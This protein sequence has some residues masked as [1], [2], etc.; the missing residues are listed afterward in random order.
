VC[1]HSKLGSMSRAI[2]LVLWL[3]A[4]MT[5]MAGCA[6]RRIPPQFYGSPLL[7]TGQLDT[8]CLEGRCIVLDPGHGGAFAGALG[9]GGL[10]EDDVNLGVALYLWGLLRD[11]GAE[12]YLTR[13]S[14]TDFLIGQ[15]A[16]LGDDLRRRMEV[17][18]GFRPELFISL[19]HNADMSRSPEKNRIE[20]YFKMSDDGPSKDAAALI[21]KHLS[22]NLSIEQG[23]LVAGNYFVLR[24][25][26]CPAVLGEPSYLTN[27]W[28]EEKLKLAQ[29]QLLEAQAYFAGIVEYFSR[30]TPHILT[31]SPCDTVIHEAR[32]ALLASIASGREGIDSNEVTC[33]LDGES[34][35]VGVNA[36]ETLLTAVAEAPLAGGT[37]ELCFCYRNRKG[38]SSGQSCCNF[39]VSL[40]AASIVVDAYP[41]GLPEEGGLLVVARTRDANGN[42]MRDGTPVLF[43]SSSGSFSEDSVGTLSGIAST[44]F[45]ASP[46]TGE[47]RIGVTCEAVTEQLVM[48]AIPV[49]TRVLR[50]TSEGER[51]ALA[52]VR[53]WHGDS[54][55]CE[56]TPQG[57][58]VIPTDAARELVLCSNGF[59]P[60]PISSD[61]ISTRTADRVEEARMAP[62]ARAALRR[63][64]VAVD[65]GTPPTIQPAG[66]DS[67]RLG[68]AEQLVGML[69]GAGAEVL[70][71][72]ENLT[73]AERVKKA[74]LFGA[75]RYLRLD[76]GTQKSPALLH[77][78]GS[79]AGNSLAEGCA[80]WWNETLSSRRPEVREDAHYV[81]RQT[82]CPA[83]VLRLALNTKAPCPEF[84]SGVAY[85]L[86]LATLSSFGLAHPDMCRL[87]V[88]SPASIRD[89]R[90]FAV[91]D[92][93]LFLPFPEHGKTSFFCAEGRHSLRFFSDRRKGE[94]EF[95]E[96]KEG[97]RVRRELTLH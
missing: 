2:A 72:D 65:A 7:D 42:A 47:G 40:P 39:E 68:I 67:L 26:P 62:V 54:L 18:S 16:G 60:E 48:T 77:Y 58:A 41:E 96:L 94:L 29:K 82:S 24:N 50:V 4:A 92:E 37:H 84:S 81:L 71:L 90:P 49:R 14:D 66:E 46:S 17:A 88:T 51:E 43:S 45:F 75:Q 5:L 36:E 33:T 34:L 79:I 85:V 97:E 74:E 31:L 78:P 8:S 61:A 87:D 55:L 44:V 63:Q 11:A 9:W 93:F 69:T 28:V 20:T 80:A 52:S 64:R 70:L 86:Y 38:N 21:H 3:M 1:I 53:V 25:A 73:D 27:P 22:E 76:T 12:V 95:I 6:G 89:E 10:E 56:T 30:G 19:H 13:S 57:L 23:E 32:P 15:E 91:L 83:L 35:A 59:L